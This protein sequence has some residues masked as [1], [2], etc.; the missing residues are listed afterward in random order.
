[1]QRTLFTVYAAERKGTAIMYWTW[2]A[3][4]DFTCGG[5][6]WGRGRGK[7]REG[8]GVRKGKKERRKE[9]EGEERDAL[10]NEMR[11]Y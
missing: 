5:R 1:M 2:G 9:K 8:E 4:G 7:R 10:K 6:Q 11:K 3:G